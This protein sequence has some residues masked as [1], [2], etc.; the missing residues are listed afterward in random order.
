MQVSQKGLVA[1]PRIENGA[2]I[3]D[4]C[5]RFGFCTSVCPTYVL[6]GDEN[7][8]PRGRI[9]L[10]KAML[11]SGMAPE[12]RTVTHVDRCL[13]CLSCATTCAAG[14]DYRRLVDTAR[15]YIEA[16]KARPL[17][18]RAYRRTL[19]RVLRSPRLLRMAMVL[20]RPFNGW[21]AR[22]P[23]RA[24]ALGRIA[25]APGTK[26]FARRGAGNA[27]QAQAGGRPPTRSVALL[28]GCVQSML[29]AE[30]NA[31][32]RRVLLRAGVR[33]V[34]SP[35]AIRNTCCGAL[36]LHMGYRATARREAARY[37]DCWAEMLD[38]GEIDAVV[39]TTSGCGS[40]VRG[41]GDLFADDPLRHARASAVAEAS[42]DVSELLA[43]HE[44]SAAGSAHLG[45]RAVYHDACSLRHGQRVVRPPRSVLAKLGY[46]VAE[47]P[48]A[49]LCCGSAGTYNLLQPAIADRL[50][51]RKAGNI[52]ATAPDVIVSGNLGCLVQ[53][54][55]FT[56]VPVAHLAQLVDWATGGPPPRG[57]EDFCPRT[58]AITESPT[59]SDSGPVIAAEQEPADLA[60]W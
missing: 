36:A 3:A 43:Q 4:A 58:G 44:L 10:I 25:R 2:R 47:V 31:A 17:G 20:A 52:V 53:I 12:R 49:H 6:D 34:E 16:W 1:Q 23:G 51:E 38:A 32:A 29:G 13:T 19:V 39:L 11:A 7:D 21:L 35:Q 33:V 40:V 41:Y 55:R 54:S 18:E 24:G 15:E 14:V 28:D 37:V 45:A 26:A 27:D 22:L 30:I 5:V 9:A 46:T 59:G 8:S 48:E 42:I 56:T 50:G 60:L 57:L